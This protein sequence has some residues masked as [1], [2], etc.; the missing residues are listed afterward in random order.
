MM[1]GRK[2]FVPVEN[3]RREIPQIG[4]GVLGYRFMGRAHSNAYYRMPVF[5]WPPVARPRLVAPSRLD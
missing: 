3:R 4:I 2:G 1:D 5:F